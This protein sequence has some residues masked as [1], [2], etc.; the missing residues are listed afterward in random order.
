MTT[1]RRS[2]RN[3]GDS[4]PI[5]SLRFDPDS[6]V[7]AA[8]IEGMPIRIPRLLAN[9]TDS[10]PPS[11]KGGSSKRK[12]AASESPLEAAFA[13]Q[14]RA[15]K[16]PEP[17][18]EYRFHPIR[19]WR[20]DFAWVDQKIAVELEGAV[21]T[22]GRHTRG[23]GFVADCEKQNAAQLRGWMVLRFADV[24]LKDGTAIAMTREAL[25]L[26]PVTL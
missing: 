6:Q 7:T 1:K 9:S 16:M 24:H 15:L 5:F 17:V 21:W 18:R 3:G 23:T 14:I 26:G 11:A 25:G 22:R 2:I 8:H 12:M 4:G 20:F 10:S 19:L 13:R